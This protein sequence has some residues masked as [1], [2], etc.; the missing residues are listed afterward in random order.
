[1]LISARVAEGNLHIAVE[2]DG[3]GLSEEQ[4]AAVM[5]RGAKLGE[6]VPGWGLGLGIVADIAALN[7]GT[8]AIGRSD[9]GGVKAELSLPG[10]A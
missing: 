10:S 5:Q 3:P 7:D 4:T 2:D 8:I 9:L 6:T 1:M